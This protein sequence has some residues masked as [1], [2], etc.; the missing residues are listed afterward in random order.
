MTCGFQVTDCFGRTVT[1]DH[2]NWQRHLARGR[3]PEVVPYLGA[4]PRVLSQP[5]VVMEAQGDGAYHYYRRGLGRGRFRNAWLIAI[6][7]MFGH[8]AKVVSWRFMF[9]IDP[10]GVQRWPI[11]APS[12]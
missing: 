5:D 8:Q 3:H 1:L 11:P 2:A 7:A 9:Q 10:G 12:T 6:V 4:L